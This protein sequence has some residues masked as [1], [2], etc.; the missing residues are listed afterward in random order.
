M[1]ETHTHEWSNDTELFNLIETELY[2]PVVGDILDA[3]GRYHQFLPQA[4]TPADLNYRLVGRAMPVLMID[5]HGP[6]EKPFGFLTEALDQLEPQEVWIASGGDMRC[7]Y[8]GELL[9]ATARMRGAAGAVVNGP[10][11]DTPKMLEQ[12]WPVF[13]RGRY[14]QDSSVRTQVANF[15]CPIEV[16]GVWINPG[17]IVFADIDGVLIVPQELEAEVITKALEKARTENIVRKEIENGLSST[18]AFAKYGVL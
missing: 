6:Q 18:A 12:N 11:R 16:D 2:T 1:T 9:T 5:V 10:H 17:D 15:R 4:I 3:L 13:S 7:A 8:W 14:A